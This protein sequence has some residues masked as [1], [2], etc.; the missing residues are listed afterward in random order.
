MTATYST[1]AVSRATFDEIAGKLT[2]AGYGASFSKDF[3]QRNL[4]NMQGLALVVEEAPA[5][6]TDSKAPLTSRKP[7][8]P[9][10][11]RT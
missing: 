8:L 6:P 3:L 10:A 9:L 7:N 11:R 1:L 2:A 5:A 4:I